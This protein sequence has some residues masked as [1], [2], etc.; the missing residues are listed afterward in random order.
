MKTGKTLYKI[1]D[2]SRCAAPPI[3]PTFD[4]PNANGKN[5]QEKAIKV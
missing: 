5:L 3:V 1:Q 4:A 2:F